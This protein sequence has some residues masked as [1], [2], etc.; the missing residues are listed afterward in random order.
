M[1]TTE[2]EKKNKLSSTNAIIAC[3]IIP[4]LIC[5]F[6]TIGITTIRSR[7]QNTLPISGKIVVIDETGKQTSSDQVKLSC[8]SHDPPGFLKSSDNRAK[9][10]PVDG[11]GNFSGMIPDCSAT[12]FGEDNEGKYAG[13]CEFKPEQSKSELRIELNPRYTL[14]GRLVKGADFVPFADEELKISCSRRGEFGSD[15]PFG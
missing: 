6:T 3:C 13:I 2:L 11:N 7:S 8:F 10:F 15:F 14:T 9:K 5:L 1:M 4:S 12:L